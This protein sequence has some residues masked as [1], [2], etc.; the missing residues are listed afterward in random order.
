VLNRAASATATSSG[1][2]AGAGARWHR[3]Q[4]ADRHA[5]ML[6][7][8]I[9]GLAGMATC[10]VHGTLLRPS[11]PT[12][13]GSTALPSPCSA[14]TTAAGIV[15]RVLFASS[16]RSSAAAVGHTAVVVIYV[17]KAVILLSVVI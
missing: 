7:G 14:A 2:N 16:T 5:M 8:A 11:H 9:G 4:A 17:I 13:Y 1:G 6:S 10:S 12:A 3:L 15:V